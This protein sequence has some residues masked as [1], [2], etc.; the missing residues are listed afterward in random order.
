MDS[1]WLSRQKHWTN[2]FR[3]S[4][5]GV[6][7]KVLLRVALERR[8][9]SKVELR[10]EGLMAGR[11]YQIVDVL[12]NATVVGVMSRHDGLDF[13]LAGGI[14]GQLAAIAIAL[15]IVITEVI[16]LPDFDGGI[17]KHITTSIEHLPERDKGSPGSPGA[18]SVAVVG[19]S[20]L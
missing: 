2:Q 16:G 11:G 15:G 6:A 4:D 12:A 17:G 9:C 7:A 13:V 3:G 14:H 10:H 8:V 19:A 20:L 5:N 18:R 1:F